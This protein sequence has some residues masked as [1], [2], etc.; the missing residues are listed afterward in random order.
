MSNRSISSNDVNGAGTSSEGSSAG[1]PRA[2]AIRKNEW[3]S[4]LELEIIKR[5]IE[6][7][8]Q[9]EHGSIEDTAQIEIV[10][11]ETVIRN[12]QEINN[13]QFDQE[14]RQIIEQLKK[15]MAGGRTTEEIMM[16]NVDQEKVYNELNGGGNSLNDVPDAEESRRFWGDI[17]S[18]EKEYN[19]GWIKDLKNKSEH[20]QKSKDVKKQCRKIPHCRAPGKDGFQRYWSK[21]LNKIYMRIGC[22]LNKI[23]EGEDH[24]PTWMTY[25]RTV[26]CQKD[27]AKG[28]AVGNYRPITCLCL[29]WKLL[30]GMI[31]E[32][33][34]TYL[35]KENLL[36]GE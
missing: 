21:N 2:R 11:E 3:L 15:I 4:E 17:W 7:E 35:E 25:D 30:T 13:V 6:D 1:V 29:M 28:N 16:F 9:N 19:S 36:P 34:Y 12:D 14:Q 31:A 23:L 18:V 8:V 20:F 22:Q 24:L 10:N 32:E 27:P 33:M 5:T 26:L